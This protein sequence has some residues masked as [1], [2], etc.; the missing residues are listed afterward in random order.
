M[1]DRMAVLGPGT[2]DRDVPGPDTNG[3]DSSRDEER[4][5]SPPGWTPYRRTPPSGEPFVV[6]VGR[7]LETVAVEV[8]DLFFNLRLIGVAGKALAMPRRV[9]MLSVTNTL[10][11]TTSGLK[12]CIA[13]TN[14]TSS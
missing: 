2:L 4:A 14:A 12:S 11:K 7:T 3:S 13:S 1:G 9:A 10:S 5:S 8:L 6:D